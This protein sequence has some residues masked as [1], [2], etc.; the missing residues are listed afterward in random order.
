MDNT[1]L[2]HIEVLGE[3]GFRKLLSDL[4]SSL[5]N[6]KSIQENYIPLDYNE[7]PN[8]DPNKDQ[9]YNLEEYLEN[10]IKERI[11]YWIQ[12]KKED[13]EFDD[14]VYFIS[15][16]NIGSI[17]DGEIVLQLSHT[18]NHKTGLISGIS[19][20][21]IEKGEVITRPAGTIKDG[22]II[23]NYASDTKSGLITAKY[24]KAL[25]DLL[26]WLIFA[27]TSNIPTENIAGIIK[28]IDCGNI[29]EGIINLDICDEILNKDENKVLKKNG[30]I[31]SIDNGKINNGKIELNLSNKENP[32]L[33][34]DIN[35]GEISNNGYIYLPSARITVT[36]KNFYNEI[37]GLATSGKNTTINDG[38]IYL[39]ISNNNKLGLIKNFK[40]P[41]Y[42]TIDAGMINIPE[43][44]I[45][46]A[47]S[48]INAKN[49][50]EPEEKYFKDI[51]I[52]NG[53]III[54]TKYLLMPDQ[55]KQLTD[56][57]EF[58]NNF[59]NLK[60]NFY[61]LDSELHNLQI[62]IDLYHRNDPN[63][64][65]NLPGYLD[66]LN[67]ITGSTSSIWNRPKDIIFIFDYK[68]ILD[69][70]TI[71]INH[72]HREPEHGDKYELESPGYFNN[73]YD[74]D[75]SLWVRNYDFNDQTGYIVT[76]SKMPS[77]Y[78]Y[79]TFQ[80]I[81]KIADPESYQFKIY[82]SIENNI[83]FN[84]VSTWN[85]DTNQPFPNL[86]PDNGGNYVYDDNPNN[87]KNLYSSLG[88]AKEDKTIINGYGNQTQMI[89]GEFLSNGKSIGNSPAISIDLCRDNKRNTTDYIWHKEEIYIELRHISKY[90][91]FEIGPGRSSINNIYSCFLIKLDYDSYEENNL[92]TII[93]GA[94]C[95]N[96]IN[97]VKPGDN[98]VMI[99]RYDISTRLFKISYKGDEN[100]INE[101]KN[102]E[103]SLKGQG[104]EYI[105]TRISISSDHFCYWGKLRKVGL[106]N[107]SNDKDFNTHNPWPADSILII[108]RDEKSDLIYQENDNLAFGK[109]EFN[110]DGTRVI[111][112]DNL[113]TIDINE[114]STQVVHI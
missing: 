107:Y 112:S 93:F 82:N 31:R 6:I 38:I 23:L 85:H 25:D 58:N 12:K 95:S 67:Y 34:K 87:N 99:V 66:V 83:D 46:F 53:E 63:L 27:N 28:N 36:D 77:I 35:Y 65:K 101:L 9:K 80:I 17:Y 18:A 91:E 16:I 78:F 30:L 3:I 48:K 8:K 49:A 89:I 39:P 108:P 92:N 103:G 74:Y 40:N 47:I 105:K 5:D 33:I 7:I 71:E 60:R 64:R 75:N 52:E 45:L 57:R 61:A 76:Y 55:Y 42:G 98:I 44:G 1:S 24:K 79:L 14:S 113:A 110:F 62:L 15:W 59:S 22:E 96:F 106:Q 90:I 51:K 94:D 111:L 84:Y 41:I 21:I 29:K 20:R 104:L 68:D 26:H 50:S 43:S 10:Y 4:Q 100:K 56:V 32:G 109:C 2:S 69:E 102:I 73:N 97:N 88:L 11:D 70:I 37:I 114:A 13:G 72:N 81:T 86:I 54:P 19:S